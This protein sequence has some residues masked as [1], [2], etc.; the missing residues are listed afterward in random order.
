MPAFFHRTDDHFGMGIPETK[1]IDPFSTTDWEGV[2]VEPDV[3]VNP[4]QALETAEK[5]AERLQKK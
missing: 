4:A 3:K 2:G 5:L 1:A